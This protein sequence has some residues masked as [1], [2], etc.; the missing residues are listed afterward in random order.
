[1]PVERRIGLALF[2][3]LSILGGGTQAA[4][5]A[6][7]L[8]GRAISAIELDCA[9]PIDR[10]GLLRMLPMKVGD[11]LRSSDLE[12][13]RWL[14]EQKGI[15]THIEIDVQSRDAGVAIIVHLVRKAVVNAVRFRGN[16]AIGDSELGRLVRLSPGTTFTETLRDYGV[17]RIH[18]RYV[19]EGF[20][21]VE[22]TARVNETSPGE[23]DVTFDI[24]EGAPL[25]VATVDIGGKVPVPME[26]LREAVAIEPG[27]RYVRAKQ[28]EADKALLRVLREKRY[29][30]AQVQS[31]WEAEGEG[32][33]VL[34]FSIDPGPPFE[35]TFRGNRRFSDDDLLELIRLD[36]RPIVTDGTWRE[37]AR[38]ARRAYQEAGYYFADIS[39]EI[40]SGTPKRVRFKIEEGGV[41]HVGGVS[42]E[43]NHGLSANQL[44]EPMATRPP[45]WIPWRRGVLLD[46]VFDDDLK[47]LWYLYRRHGFESAEIVDARRRF[48]REHGKIY[49]TVV[50][51]EGPRTIVGEIERV[52]L[53]AIA[54]NP[55]QLGIS[56]G[57]ALDTEA[58]ETARRAL[59][60]ALAKRGYAEAKVTAEVSS[61][62]SQDD[63][64]AA[65]VRFAAEPGPRERVGEI[66]IQHNI[67]T[68]SR[69]V[70]RELP[71]KRGEPLD[72]DALLRGQ[73]NVYGLGLFRS[74]SIRPLKPDPIQRAEKLGTRDV[75]VSVAEKPPGS[76]QWGAGYNTRDGVRT[77]GEISNNNLQGLGRRLSLRGELSLDS[78]S[79]N[80]NEYIGTLGFV[81]PRLGDTRWRLRSDL[82]AQ[83]STRSV[84][85]F[86]VERLAFIPAID[87]EL[88]PNL[89]A[90]LEFQAEQSQ[91]FD[92][93]AD[94]L[95]FNPRD[96]GRLR[97][98]SLGPFLVYDGRDDAF[99]PRR[100]VY[101]SLRLRLAPGELG[102]DVPFV[103]L[104]VQH[105]H[106]VPLVND[107]IFVYSARGGW[108]LALKS[109]DQIPI[110]ERFFLGGR[111]TVRGFS[112]NTIGPK[113]ALQFD[114]RGRPTGAGD[115]PLGGDFVL[116]LN[117]E[118]RFPIAFG[119][120]GA[121]FVDGGGV[122][123]QD[124]SISIHDFRRS[125]GPG[126]RY[127]T[128]VGPISLDY[129][130]KLDRRGDESV[131]DVHFSVG[132]IF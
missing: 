10:Q 68:K 17:Q 119:V 124:R 78:T 34:Q 15:F 95:D 20:P 50:I 132:T 70:F 130:F 57:D 109:G 51:E 36:S 2:L 90:G 103:K 98:F 5:Q 113:G 11:P 120:G 101:D 43:G 105:T 55:P 86:S 52:G 26:D 61:R 59:L 88:V 28:R 94:V 56:V 35:L 121:V 129:G 71:F 69:V 1:M 92:V 82:I 3:A 112:E 13:A 18:D 47:R 111:T 22:V 74:V 45:S 79:F 31:R 58:V 8:V 77:F 16:E 108:A 49:L 62:P 9:A 128:P 104:Q 83:R 80:P 89:R 46:D 65:T 19:A 73:S 110:R 107:V 42:F 66:I 40:E 24:A 12:E 60:E 91:V 48:D 54:D 125:I 99:I 85:Q 33:G 25:R 29:Y 44:L 100:G 126:L 32:S 76:I 4:G 38:R 123:L 115:D 14:L 81:E 7:D 27:D 118:I 30:E 72:P 6:P 37:L 64:R 67:D 106:Y 84:D 21:T 93:A 39:T 97:T 116:N 102:S 63:T 87:R 75:G 122:Y 131:G 127:S 117:T 41:F 96:E 114:S 23:V 53:E